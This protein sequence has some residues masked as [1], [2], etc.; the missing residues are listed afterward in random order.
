MKEIIKE[1]ERSKKYG[2]DG[3]CYGPDRICQAIDICPET[4]G[5]EFVGTIGA[6][7]TLAFFPVAVVLAIILMIKGGIG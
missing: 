5:A 1:Q 4:K 3:K 2:C 6:V 7:L